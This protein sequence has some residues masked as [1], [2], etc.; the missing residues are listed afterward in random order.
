M[1]HLIFFCALTLCLTACGNN[2]PKGIAAKFLDCL[3]AKDYTKAVKYCTPRGATFV[4]M[5]GSMDNGQQSMSGYKILSDSIE[6]DR[7]W[8]TYEMKN[9]PEKAKATLELSK[10]DGKWKVDPTMRK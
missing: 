4:S 5:I 6:G 8:V 2:S 7:A 3:K 10:I 9:G 1:K